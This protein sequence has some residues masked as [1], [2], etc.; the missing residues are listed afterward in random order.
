MTLRHR[1]G[2][3]QV[4]SVTA[5]AATLLVRV[6]INSQTSDT[7]PGNTAKTVKFSRIMHGG[8]TDRIRFTAATRARACRSAWSTS[9]HD[10]ASVESPEGPLLARAGAWQRSDGR[11]AG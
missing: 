2:C 8:G 1:L 7:P 4:P 11:H 6:R 9:R 3:K 5:H 10:R